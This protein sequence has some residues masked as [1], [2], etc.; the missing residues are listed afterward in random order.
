MRIQSFFIWF[1]YSRIWIRTIVLSRWCLL[2]HH[3]LVVIVVRN[4]LLGGRC[5]QMWISCVVIDRAVA[6]VGQRVVAV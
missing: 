1:M 3:H 4:H 6:A 2:A 5:G